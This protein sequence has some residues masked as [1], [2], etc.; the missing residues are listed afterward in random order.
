MTRRR[1]IFMGSPG[2]AIPALDRLAE[3][4]DIVAVYSQ[5]PRRA[6]RGMKEQLQPLAAHAA[7]RGFACF[8]PASLS[9]D[10]DLA[11][12]AGH[13]ADIFIVVAY[14][15]LLP[16]RVLDMPRF[17]CINGHASLLP[18]WRG[19][20]PIQ[21]AI[22][23]GDSETGIC[24]MLME[25]G[26]DTGPVVGR[27]VCPIGD[28]D[29][30]GSLHDRLALL[31]AE[32]LGAVVDDLPDVLENAQPQDHGAA[33]YARKISPGEAEIDWTRPAAELALHIRAFAPVPGA[34][35]AGAR[36]RVRVLKAHVAS[37]AGTPG[38]F[39][40]ADVDGG[41]Q[42]ATGD[43]VLTLETVQPAGSKPMAASAFLNGAR[44]TPGAQ[45]GPATPA[46]SGAEHGS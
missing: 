45:M 25:K 16:Q 18:R 7:T 46:G 3:Q 40:G 33:T 26:L 42:V 41:M 30:A 39:L 1:I 43:G 27:R 20:A 36:G 4:H 15:L 44:L 11:R 37:G 23:A 28:D 29:T 38:C 21:R 31:N 9:A 6:G 5:P 10:D 24:A 17:G 2:F 22:A 35:F 8:H 32:L 13:G 12:L 14:G 19:A 34:W